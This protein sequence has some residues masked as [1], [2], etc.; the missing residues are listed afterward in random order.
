MEGK[1]YYAYMDFGDPPML[2]STANVIQEVVRQ[3]IMV[4]MV[5][6]EIEKAGVISLFNKI[7]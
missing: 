3:P 2:V 1:T 7:A 6:G 4:L 5:L